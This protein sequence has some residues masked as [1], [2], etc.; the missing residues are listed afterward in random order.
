[1]QFEPKS[2][3][4]AKGPW[5]KFGRVKPPPRSLYNKLTR[6]FPT[7]LLPKVMT[8][9][10]DAVVD[11]R[12]AEL[13]PQPYKLMRE[14][15]A[16][17]V[18]QIEAWSALVSAGR[19]AA[20]MPT[21]CGKTLTASMIASSYP[22]VPVLVTVPNKRLLHQN[23][24]EMGEF[25]GEPVGIYGDR[26]RKLGPRVL[27]SNI[28]A[29]VAAIKKKDPEVMA[30]LASVQVWIC[31][32]CH[33][34]GADSYRDLSAVMPLAFNRYGVT[35][36]WMREDGC[37]LI[38]EGVLGD[39][40]FELSYDEA[41]RLGYLTEVRIL[42]RSLPIRPRVRA[43]FTRKPKY[44]PYYDEAVVLN[45]DDNAAIVA[46][47]REAVRLGLTP[48]LV[49][50]ERIE[51]GIALSEALD[52]P[53]AN[54]EDDSADVEKALAQFMDGKFPVLVASRILNVGV[55]LKQLRSAFNAAGGDSRIA[56][57]Q[58]PGRG[59]RL[60]P[61]KERFYYVDY[62]R[63]DPWYLGKHGENRW[64]TYSKFFRSHRVYGF[65]HLRSL[66]EAIAKSEAKFQA[67]LA[68]A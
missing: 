5:N 6:A 29:L 62:H 57:L 21:G 12:P 36:T 59:T 4:F 19:G 46:D 63:D 1:L 30:F 49:M 66:A 40:A 51:H 26:N 47:V 48:A 39:V 31:D 13:T 50:V 37:E 67:A 53:F 68:A 44:A 22:D 9:V 23:Y 43:K 25:L 18:K 2:G 42:I 58:K 35:A 17:R 20:I 56:A 45:E 11:G 14:G 27:V 8:L 28:Q 55:D 3:A 10:A 54:G 41:F 15:Y 65:S 38:M 32:E 24:Q 33:G 64:A 60:W 61:G 16:P 34:A 7:G 52:C